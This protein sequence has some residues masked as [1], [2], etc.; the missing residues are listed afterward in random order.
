MQFIYPF[1]ATQS[2]NSPITN[3]M[4]LLDQRGPIRTQRI[5]KMVFCPRLNVIHIIVYMSRGNIELPR[6]EIPP[7]EA[8]MLA[9]RQGR[10]PNRLKGYF[11]VPIHHLTNES[12]HKIQRKG[13][14]LH[15]TTRSASLHTNSKSKSL[16][17]E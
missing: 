4:P 8:I 16:R 10:H 15:D 7:P 13:N 5:S 14:G 12:S 1:K 11:P 3:S 9:T 6:K 2:N 17:R